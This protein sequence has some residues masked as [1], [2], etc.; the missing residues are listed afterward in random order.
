[1]IHFGTILPAGPIARLLARLRAADDLRF[2]IRESWVRH[3]RR[4]QQSPHFVAVQSQR[5]TRHLFDGF[6][7][8][9]RIPHNFGASIIANPG[10]LGRN[11]GLVL[12]HGIGHPHFID[13]EPRD[14]LVAKARVAALR[15]P[16]L[17]SEF[18]ATKGCIK[19]TWNSLDA[20]AIRIAV[21]LRV[22]RAQTIA[23]A[24][25]ITRITLPGIMLL[26]GCSAGKVISPRPAAGPLFIHSRP[27]AIV[28]SVTATP[29]SWPLNS[30]AASWLLMLA[31]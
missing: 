18:H 23:T 15:N 4:V 6:P 25:G 3:P 13:G 26:P 27:L 2:S 28:R 30:T 5:L 12:S 19:L 31:K 22:T 20:P 1:L 21:S 29:R 8:R 17:L 16:M 14:R 7:R 24:F 11:N 9:E 10:R